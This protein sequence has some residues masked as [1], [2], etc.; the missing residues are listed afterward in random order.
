MKKLSTLAGL[1]I[2]FIC[3]LQAQIPS[4]YYQF[5]IAGATATYVTGNN[6]YG[7]IVGYCTMGGVTKGFYF[8]GVDTIIAQYQNNSSA[9]TYFGA[10]NNHHLIGI[11]EPVYVRYGPL[12]ILPINS[13]ILSSS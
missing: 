8:N 9:N 1:L 3:L 5:D 7:E 11:K 13:F 12:A 10:I 6:N 4:K 2:G